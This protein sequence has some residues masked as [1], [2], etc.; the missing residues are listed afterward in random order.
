MRFNGSRG[1]VLVSEQA[2]RLH[3]EAKTVLNGACFEGRVR[4]RGLTAAE[5]DDQAEQLRRAWNIRRRGVISGGR[6]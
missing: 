6:Q 2:Q 4:V 5:R 3:P 1:L